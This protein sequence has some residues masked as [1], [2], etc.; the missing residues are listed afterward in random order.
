[1]VEQTRFTGVV[2]DLDGTL[3]NSAPDIADALNMVL[4]DLGRT[5]QTEKTLH[6][7]IARG[8]GGLLVRI[9]ESTG[10]IPDE[11]RQWVEKRFGQYYLTRCT[12]VASLYPGVMSC[13]HKLHESRIVM[14]ICTNKRQAGADTVVNSIG[15]SPYMC[16]V[17]GGDHGVMKPD[18]AHLTLTLDRMGTPPH[19]TIM[20]G[21][22]AAD[23]QAAHALGIACVLVRYGYAS[24]SV[25]DL[26]ADATVDSL[27]ELPDLLFNL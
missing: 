24:Q 6:D 14:G 25:D 11:G 9:M 22:T 20:V 7:Q 10:G 23:L 8:W 17:V 12:R 26:G 16:A 27:D 13:L 4:A 3:V 18:P 19:S 5:A 1:M 2:F 21:D 15:L